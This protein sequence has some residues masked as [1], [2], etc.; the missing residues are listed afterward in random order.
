VLNFGRQSS[1]AAHT[2]AGSAESV[3]S[4]MRSELSR[5]RALAAAEV[6]HQVL[7]L[8]SHCGTIIRDEPFS[9]RCDQHRDFPAP[10]GA[11]H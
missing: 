2:F 11:A 3:S 9:R 7:D 6:I 1:C 8:G 5:G 4:L 10:A